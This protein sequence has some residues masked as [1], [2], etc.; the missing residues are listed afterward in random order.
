M[1]FLFYSIQ[2]LTYMKNWSR[3]RKIKHLFYLYQK[4]NGKWTG[5]LDSIETSCFILV[6]RIQRWERAFPTSGCSLC[7]CSDLCPYLSLPLSHSTLSRSWEPMEEVSSSEKIGF[8]KVF[9]INVWK[10]TNLIFCWGMFNT[11]HNKDL[12]QLNNINLFQYL[13]LW[14]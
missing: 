11:K 5:G 14:H 13:F 12:L 1:N 10:Y 8:F 4:E 2:P 6:L 7:R 9:E 3:G